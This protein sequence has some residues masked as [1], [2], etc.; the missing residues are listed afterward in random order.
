M[1]LLGNLNQEFQAIKAI[2]DKL[3]NVVAIPNVL[4]RNFVESLKDVDPSIFEEPKDSFSIYKHTGGAE[5]G[6]VGKDYSPQQPKVIFEMLTESLLE[7]N[8]D[9]SKIKYDEFYDGAKIRFN[10]PLRT[11]EFKN[12]AGLGDVTETY[13]NL[14]TGFDGKTSTSMFI[15]TTRLACMN[16]M[17]HPQ[18]E[19]LTKFRNTKGNS[20]KVVG[21]IEDITRQIENVNNLEYHFKQLDK[22]QVNQK[23]IDTYLSKVLGYKIADYSELPKASQKILDTVNEQIEIEFIDGGSTLFSLYNGITRYTNHHARGHEKKEYLQYASGLKLNDKAMK[24][25]L[26]LVY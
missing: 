5:L 16:V 19:I 1:N 18:T 17:K 14:A 8:L 10:I 6:R 7:A 26:E 23:M 4:N 24:H 9:V 21:L 15:S 11:I 25:A 2:E 12:N 13:L 20:T 3:F 22:I